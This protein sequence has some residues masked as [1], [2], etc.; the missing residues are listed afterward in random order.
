[1]PTTHL[2]T[3][4]G[5]GVGCVPGAVLR[6]ALGGNHGGTL[7]EALKAGRATRRRQ[8]L[9][10]VRDLHRKGLVH[11]DVKPQNL[12][13]VHADDV[14]KLIDFVTC[15]AAGKSQLLVYSLR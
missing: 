13:K 3:H 9:V 15:S 12:V 2:K 11:G 8:V 14:W 6:G 5:P 7:F 4:L 10:A 1:M